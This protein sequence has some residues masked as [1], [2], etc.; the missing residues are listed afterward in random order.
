VNEGHGESEGQKKRFI[1]VF[2]LLETIHPQ[3]A[4]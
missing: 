4:V 1:A 2:L 3:R